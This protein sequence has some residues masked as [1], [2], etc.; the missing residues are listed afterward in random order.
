MNQSQYEVSG[1]IRT[2]SR[3][4]PNDY[5]D[6]PVTEN[7]WASDRDVAEVMVTAKLR[8]RYENPWQYVSWVCPPIIRVVSKESF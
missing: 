2:V 7:A 1:T 6:T 3:S 5:M 4:N 8:D